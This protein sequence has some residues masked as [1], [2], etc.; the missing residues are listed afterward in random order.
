[1]T[2]VCIA[3]MHRFGTSLVTNLLKNCGVYLGREEDISAKG[4]DNPEGFW[5]NAKHNLP[6]VY[7]EFFNRN[8]MGRMGTPQEVA[9]AVAFLASPAASFITGTNM[10][11][12]GGFTDKVYF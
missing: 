1:M 8:P 3:G 4:F 6:D 10:V 7:E 12:D 5:E 9:N 11:V 2:I